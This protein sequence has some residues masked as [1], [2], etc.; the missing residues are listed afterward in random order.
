MFLLDF[1]AFGLRGRRR[2]L[3]KNT[4]DSPDTLATSSP[5]PE[6]KIDEMATIR[7][8]IMGGVKVENPGRYD[9]L[10][11]SPLTQQHYAEFNRQ[12]AKLDSARLSKIL[13]WRDQELAEL[14]ADGNNLFYP[15]SGPDFLNAYLFFPNCENYLM[16]GLEPNGKLV[17]LDNMPPNYLASLRNALQKIFERNYFITS[18]MGG[19]LWGKGVLPIVNIFMART[20]NQIVQMKRFYL[21]KE[22]KAVFLN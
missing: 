11:Q 16:F 12:W 7:A 9:S 1:P 20:G 19:D 22:G 2:G 18:Y 8:K 14:Q 17:D 21:D 4:P 15:F 10:L 3:A 13:P 6:V 5:T